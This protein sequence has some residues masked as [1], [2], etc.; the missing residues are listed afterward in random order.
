MNEEVALVLAFAAIGLGFGAPPAG[1][2]IALAF[3]HKTGMWAYGAICVLITALVIAVAP[4]DRI[5]PVLREDP[6]VCTAPPD[7]AASVPGC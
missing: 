3:G 2:L 4:K 7:K 1:F 5:S 6:L